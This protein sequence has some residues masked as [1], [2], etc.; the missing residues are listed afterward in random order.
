MG[1]HNCIVAMGVAE[2]VEVVTRAHSAQ[3]EISVDLRRNHMGI[4]LIFHLLEHMAFP[5]RRHREVGEVLTTDN[6]HL[7]RQVVLEDS[8]L[9]HH[10]V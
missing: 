9:N 2:V 1:V 10:R 4:I 6:S 8:R 7:R 5:L 3:I